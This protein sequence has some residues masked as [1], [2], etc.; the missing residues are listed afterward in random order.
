MN[1]YTELGSRVRLH[2]GTISILGKC[3]L[4]GC[5]WWRW[6]CCRYVN[7]IFCLSPLTSFYFYIIQFAGDEELVTRVLSSRRKKNSRWKIPENLA[8]QLHDKIVLE[9]GTFTTARL[10][11]VMG[12]CQEHKHAIIG[13]VRFTAGEPL[14][15]LCRVGWRQRRC[16]SVVTAT[17][18]GRSVYGKL[19]RFCICA[20]IQGHRHFAQVQWL[21]V[22]Q[23]PYGSPLIVKIGDDT[24]V[25]DLSQ[26]I[27]LCDIDPTRV[28]VE[29]SD[30]ESAWYMMRM[31]GIDTRS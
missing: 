19:V 4:H 3:T 8:E 15:G 27:E 18:N 5:G 6:R 22:P 12:N 1:T 10:T 20:L 23:Y 17:I 25:P 26:F 30:S 21:G 28:I 11:D 31:K 13:G 7:T 29:R 24:P 9:G 2:I 14:S 16:G